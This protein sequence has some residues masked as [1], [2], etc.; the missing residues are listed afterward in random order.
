MLRLLSGLATPASGDVYWQNTSIYRNAQSDYTKHMHYLSHANGLKLGL[1]V[2]QNLFLF[3]LLV[4][5]EMPPEI[6]DEKI[7]ACLVQFKLKQDTH[8]LVQNLSAGQKRRLAL[9]KCFLFPKPLWILDEPLTSLDKETQALFHLALVE[10]LQKGGIAILSLHEA[11]TLPNVK[12]L[13][14]SPC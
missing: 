4:C 11:I 14:I 2:R 7:N 10:H 6:L 3:K 9:L 13:E 8:T 12:I 5:Y 1:S